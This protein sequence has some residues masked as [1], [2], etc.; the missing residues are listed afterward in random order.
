MELPVPPAAAGV[1]AG[2]GG[3]PPETAGVPAA[4][5]QHRRPKTHRTCAAERPRSPAETRG[6]TAVCGHGRPEEGDPGPAGE[7]EG[8]ED[9]E[10]ADLS[11]L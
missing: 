5:Q 10:G 9:P 4:A 8:A 1:P 6:E 3:H 7:A 11:G 2:V